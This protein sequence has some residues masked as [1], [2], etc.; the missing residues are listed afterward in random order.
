[1]RICGGAGVAELG[2]RMGVPLYYTQNMGC[3]HPDG[4]ADQVVCDSDIYGVNHPAAYIK[5]VILKHKNIVHAV[6]TLHHTVKGGYACALKDEKNIYLFRD[7]IG[8][9]PLY[10][11]GKQF[12]SEKRA[13]SPGASMLLPGEL[14]KLPCKRL[15]LTT[16]SKGDPPAP[17]HILDALQ[18][19]V[20]QCIESDAALL[21]SG[22]LDSSI[23]AALSDA[24]LLTCGLEGCKDL[25]FSRKAA[26]LL[27]KE[28]IEVVISEKDI[29]NAIPKVLSVIDE[30]K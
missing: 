24:A 7:V 26:R 13:L 23:L 14:L 10:Y 4:V 28:L 12:S 1:M 30:K 6:K 20:Q 9:K 25:V 5:K 19:S 29:K 16:L 3:S 8:I 27:G 21:F 2:A 11:Q 15:S 22:G 18:K 17:H